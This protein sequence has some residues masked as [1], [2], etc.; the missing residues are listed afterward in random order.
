MPRD[1][2]VGNTELTADPL[3][4]VPNDPAALLLAAQS[5]LD[6]GRPF[7]THE[8][9]ELQWKRGPEAERVLWRSL[10]QL[11]VA[12]THHL[13][14]NAAGARALA[15]R[16]AAALEAAPEPTYGIDRTRLIAYARDLAEGRLSGPLR[17]KR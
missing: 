11:A 14:G 15:L 7:E 2:S 17:L 9:F 6:S 5:L 4:D 1:A 16:S 13:R 10:A 3:V 12:L 8:L